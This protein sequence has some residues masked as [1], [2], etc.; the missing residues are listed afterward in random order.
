MGGAEQQHKSERETCSPYLNA[1]E[2]LDDE[3]R[4]MRARLAA[5]AT[6]R[7]PRAS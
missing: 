2:L 1:R 6:R 7:V 5:Y 3:L 4:A